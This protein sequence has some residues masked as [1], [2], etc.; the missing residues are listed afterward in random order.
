MSLLI[1]YSNSIKN[2]VLSQDRMQLKFQ[3]IASLELLFSGELVTDSRVTL[4]IP[5]KIPMNL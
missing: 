3:I 2:V 1:F 5:Y 4:Y